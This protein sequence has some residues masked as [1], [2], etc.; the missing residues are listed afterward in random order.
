MT[1]VWIFKSPC[2]VFAVACFCKI[3]SIW[4][5]KQKTKMK[6][7]NQ[8]QKQKRKTSWRFHHISSLFYFMFCATTMTPL[9]KFNE[10]LIGPNNRQISQSQGPS[11]LPYVSVLSIKDI[12]LR[13]SL[14]IRDT[15]DSTADTLKSCNWPGQRWDQNVLY[16]TPYFPM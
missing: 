5:Q 9:G 11:F 1:L 15:S 3:V 4:K 14:R 2:K 7:T 6:Q 8:K 12:P 16:V 10:L 13:Y